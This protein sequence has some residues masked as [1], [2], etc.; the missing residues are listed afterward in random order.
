MAENKAVVNDIPFAIGQDIIDRLARFDRSGFAADYA[1]GNQ[2]WLFFGIRCHKDELRL[3]TRKNVSI[4]R[5]LPVRTRC[6][7]GGYAL[8]HS[9]YRGEG[10]EFYDADEG[11]LFRFRESANM[12][13][14]TRGRLAY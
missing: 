1:I 2:P 12:D 5:R 4:K 9:W 3:S 6:R 14:W 7:I 13:V 8:L 10:A 11:D